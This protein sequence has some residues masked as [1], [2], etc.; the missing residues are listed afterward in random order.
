LNGFAIATMEKSLAFVVSKMD[1]HVEWYEMMWKDP[2][3]GKEHYRIGPSDNPEGEKSITLT[4]GQIGLCIKLSITI[5][6][7]SSSKTVPKFYEF[8]RNE[9]WRSIRNVPEFA[10][11]IKAITFE[12]TSESVAPKF[13]NNLW[14]G[15]CGGMRKLPIG[16]YLVGHD[17]I[18]YFK[19]RDPTQSSPIQC[20]IIADDRRIIVVDYLSKDGTRVHLLD[21]LPQQYDANSTCDEMLFSSP[22]NRRP[23]IVQHHDPS[24][25]DLYVRIGSSSG[26]LFR[27]SNITSCRVCMR[28]QTE[29]TVHDFMQIGD[30]KNMFCATCVIKHIDNVLADKRVLKND[31]ILDQGKMEI[32]TIGRMFAP[33]AIITD[34]IRGLRMKF[35]FATICD[36]LRR[37]D[38]EHLIGEIVR[39]SDSIK[40]STATSTTDNAK[41]STEA[42]TT[43]DAKVSTE[44]STTDNTKVGTEASTADNTKASTEEKGQKPVPMKSVIN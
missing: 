26:P 21:K 28:Q 43:D 33:E 17:E 7:L 4:E 9:F 29:D 15:I 38:R 40:A 13:V 18:C 39:L 32:R 12:Q 35:D 16:K 11:R 42:S 25:F 22:D 5:P 24:F 36:M 30:D 19:V 8:I 37:H 10:G 23:I 6:V 44:A 31:I 2:T 41:A 14:I 27:I 1:G 20:M 3:S 34:D